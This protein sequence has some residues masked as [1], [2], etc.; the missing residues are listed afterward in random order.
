MDHET[1]ANEPDAIRRHANRVAAY[2]GLRRLYQRCSRE[3]QLQAWADYYVDV[4]CGA[5]I[6]LIAAL[7][8]VLASVSLYSLGIADKTSTVVLVR[9]IALEVAA[10]C[11]LIISLLFGTYLMRFQPILAIEQVAKWTLSILVASIFFGLWG[12]VMLSDVHVGP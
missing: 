4:F 12:V 5:C 11:L 1:G 6:C 8:F 9:C 7:L 10:G 2:V 3:L